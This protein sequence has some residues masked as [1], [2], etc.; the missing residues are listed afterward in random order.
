MEIAVLWFLS[1]VAMNTEIES[2]KAAVEELQVEV[3]INQKWIKD[4]ENWN[5]DLEA[6]VIKQAAAHSAFYA[7]QQLKNEGYEE[8]INLL[9]QK[10]DTLKEMSEGESSTTS[11]NVPNKP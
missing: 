6:T 1:M 9:N 4:L 7:G 11:S 8:D 10:V 2:N 5:N 3:I